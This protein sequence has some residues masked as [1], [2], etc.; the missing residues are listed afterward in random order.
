MSPEMLAAM[1]DAFGTTALNPP[2]T[3]KVAVAADGAAGD[4]VTGSESSEQILSALGLG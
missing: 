3:P 2:S 4:L 1:D